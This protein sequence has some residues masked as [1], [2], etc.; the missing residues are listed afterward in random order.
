MSSVLEDHKTSCW[1]KL[2][3]FTRT[4]ETRPHTFQPVYIITAEISCESMVDL[5]EFGSSNDEF[6]N[7]MVDKFRQHLTEENDTLVR[8]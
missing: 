7:Y 5:K 2:I 6:V 4:R 1:E 3:K 8:L